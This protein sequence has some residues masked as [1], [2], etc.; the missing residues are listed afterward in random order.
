M[1]IKIPFFREKNKKRQISEKTIEKVIKL[2]EYVNN[3]NLTRK[4]IED[5]TELYSVK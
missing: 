2:E 1:K 4:L 3:G 5:L